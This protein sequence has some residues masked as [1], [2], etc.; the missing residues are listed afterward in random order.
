MKIREVTV[1]GFRS[2]WNVSIADLGNINV[3]FG[4]N[5]SGKSNI[6]EALE[7]LFKV[8]QEELP[9][10]GFYQGALSN[11]ADNFTVKY[12]G[13]MM[14]T[15]NMSCKVGI[16]SEDIQ[17]LS[18]TTHNERGSILV[19]A[20]FNT[21]NTAFY[22]R[23]MGCPYGLFV[24]TSENSTLEGHQSFLSHVKKYRCFSHSH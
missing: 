5:N 13:S 8:E 2:L 9:V 24:I 4:D 6:L 3:F 19:D 20:S 12:D 1:S 23:F 14:T 22:R 21:E 11:F 10:S 16:G 17:N 15:I 7:I 18:V